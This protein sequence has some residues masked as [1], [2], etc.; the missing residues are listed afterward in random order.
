MPLK[1][2]GQDSGR[3]RKAAD[4]LAEELRASLRDG[5]SLVI[6]VG[7]KCYGQARQDIDLLIFADFDPI[8]SLPSS[9]R[10]TAPGENPQ[11][12]L[13]S[14][15][16][17]L[18]VKDHRQSDIR[19]I[20]NQVE[21]RYENRWSNVSQA[22]FEQRF[23]VKNFMQAAGKPPPFILSA[24]WLRN[25]SKG[26]LPLPP[27]DVLVG[28]PTAADLWALVG[29]LGIGSAS[30]G[31]ASGQRRLVV[32][33]GSKSTVA[34]ALSAAD[35][36]VRELRPS[37]LDRRKLER[38]CDRQ[39]R[40][41]QYSTLVGKQLL[42]FR[43][44]GGAGKTIRMLQLAK[45]IYDSSG[46][47]VLFLTYN[48]AL[49]AD[50]KRLLAI[51]GIGDRVDGPTI[52]VASSD[53]FFWSV[54]RSFDLAPGQTEDGEFPQA[55]YAECKRELLQLLRSASPE[56]IQ[57]D[58][59]AARNPD[60]FYWDC[61]CVDEAQ[62][63]PEDERDLLVALFGV[64]RLVIADGV[65]QLVRQATRCDWAS[66]ASKRRQIVTL[67]KSMR[68]KT[69]LCRFVTT[70]AEELRIPWDMDINPEI[71]GGRVMLIRG[72]YTE[73]KHRELLSEHTRLGNLPVDYM[74]CVTGAGSSDSLSL[75]SR[76]LSWGF[77][78]WDG[79]SSLE[80]GS[81]PT[82]TDQFRIVKYESSRGLEGWT[83]ACLDFD[84]F[85]EKQLR[86]GQGIP[87]DALQSQTEAAHVFASQWA[88]IPMTRGVDTL[89]L[90]VKGEG[91]LV[92]ALMVAAQTHSDFV[93]VA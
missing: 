91:A 19:F 41:T 54:L 83:V 30:S 63:W 43:G 84:L 61:V 5:D 9:T 77:K 45:S 78:V 92:S 14:F 7:A 23:S 66:L 35:L 65:D 42:I 8:L 38:I 80:R 53:S 67:R 68:L 76:L 88:L 33:C 36:F 27:T 58:P 50:V 85:F 59:T 12:S 24:I 1:I 62:D 70:V 44:R 51:I 64:T 47:R 81:F 18:E 55:Q 2:V 4:E 72:T 10:A 90:Q 49:A 82:D 57:N 20:G 21:V 13:D 37:E 48:R 3:E 15:V 26:E 93:V 75:S 73:Q 52:R 31:V 25:V 60:V 69:N 17:T 28:H 39:L 16:L 87:R 6:V 22:V 56:E 71:R 29:K 46:A 40:E 86:I 79:T 32:S 34:S 11:V 74:F 89:V